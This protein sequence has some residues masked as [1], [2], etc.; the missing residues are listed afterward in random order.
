MVIFQWVGRWCPSWD[1][2]SFQTP[3]TRACASNS[4]IIRHFRS[5][6][7]ERPWPPS[8][9]FHTLCRFWIESRVARGWRSEQAKS[10]TSKIMSGIRV[11]WA[12]ML[13]R[14]IYRFVYSNQHRQ[15][16]QLWPPTYIPAQAPSLCC[17]LCLSCLFFSGFEFQQTFLRSF[18][19]SPTFAWMKIFLSA[20]SE[21][22][23]EKT[24]VFETRTD[25]GKIMG[26]EIMILRFS[27][28]VADWITRCACETTK[29]W[30][31][32]LFFRRNVQF[33]DK[34]RNACNVNGFECTIWIS[35]Q[36]GL[37]KEWKWGKTCQMHRLN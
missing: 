8:K 15:R 14:R 22:G 3:T 2:R 11:L 18:L 17:F 6:R 32:E 9:W 5:T 19:F 28:T 4:H 10:Q 21:L 20:D 31:C 35:M 24:F 30:F 1:V 25:Y 26:F 34:R 37:L 12:L 7:L 29:R 33:A 27:V 16:L 23:N 13:Q 36:G